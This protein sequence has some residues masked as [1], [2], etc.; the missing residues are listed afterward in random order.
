[1]A[2]GNFA[3]RIAKAVGVTAQAET[4]IEFRDGY[5]EFKPPQ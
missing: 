3:E 5:A 1:M 4:A 2:E